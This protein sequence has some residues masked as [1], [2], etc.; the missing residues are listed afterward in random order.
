MGHIL[1]AVNQKGDLLIIDIVHNKYWSI[2]SIYSCTVLEFS[3]LNDS[4]LILGATNGSVIIVNIETGEVSALLKG[5]KL[6]VSAISFSKDYHCLTSTS[7]EAKIWNLRNNLELQTLQMKG[8][9]LL[10]HVSVFIHKKK[11]NNNIK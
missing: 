7:T 9:M 1:G 3:P 8:D 2:P 6:P 11:K 5:H 10:K 4:E